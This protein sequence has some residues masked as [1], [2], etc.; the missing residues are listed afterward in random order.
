MSRTG[1][2][3]ISQKNFKKLDGVVEIFL[4][5]NP[6]SMYKSFI[7]VNGTEP[8]NSALIDNTSMRYVVYGD[9]VKFLK[10]IPFVPCFTVDGYE[11]IFPFTKSFILKSLNKKEKLAVSDSMGGDL[12]FT[13]FQIASR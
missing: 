6:S 3:G 12:E 2:A 13:F 7:P 1:F 4:V 9:R 11:F 10:K 5:V 8:L